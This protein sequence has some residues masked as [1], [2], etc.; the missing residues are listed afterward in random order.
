MMIRGE[1]AT[2]HQQTRV[3]GTAR[4]WA[5]SGTEERRVARHTDS[6]TSEDMAPGIRH[7]VGTEA[8]V[9]GTDM[10][11]GSLRKAGIAAQAT[12]SAVRALAQ[13]ALGAASSSE[14][15]AGMPRQI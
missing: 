5:Q 2:A 15:M 14:D 12:R 7:T 3:A 9:A 10:G 13:S 8:A 4:K 1:A 6:R 11:T